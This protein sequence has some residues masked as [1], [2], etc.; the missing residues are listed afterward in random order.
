MSSRQAEDALIYFGVTIPNITRD[1]FQPSSLNMRQQLKRKRCCFSDDV[2]RD[3]IA[4]NND[5]HKSHVATGDQAAEV[6]RQRIATLCQI[7][8]ESKNCVTLTV[9]GMASIYAALRLAQYEYINRKGGTLNDHNNNAI[10]EE[11]AVVVFGF[12]YIDT[13]KV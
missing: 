4:N 5:F 6:I 3:C 13:L 10:L 11:T 12:P 1:C 7:E 8:N 9:S 2:L